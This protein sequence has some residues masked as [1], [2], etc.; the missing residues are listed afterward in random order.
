MEYNLLDYNHLITNFINFIE[1]NYD[2]L[3]N[4]EVKTRS[5]LIEQKFKTFLSD[6]LDFEIEGNSALGVDLPIFNTDIKCTSI[7][8]P[9]SSSPYRSINEKLF[10][11][12]YNILLFVYS[13]DNGV[14]K[15]ENCAYI[16]KHMTGCK[17]A[18]KL[19]IKLTNEYNNNNI[20]KNIAIK[21][22]KGWFFTV[23]D[24]SSGGITRIIT[25]FISGRMSTEDLIAQVNTWN[26]CEPLDLKPDW[27]T[28]WDRAIISPPCEGV[29]NYS[30]AL[31]WRLQY[32]EL[33]HDEY[34][35]DIL[36]IK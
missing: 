33:T 7:S 2:D 24:M 6:N 35:Q 11:V 16:P 21:L 18:T 28:I 1:S 34:P 30:F 15:I 36:K 19:L 20:S 29:I 31:Q 10:G 5:T 22:L 27:N 8:Q 32:T 13:I 12:D 14:F 9:Q 17:N 3:I 25:N 4:V 26:I 23:E